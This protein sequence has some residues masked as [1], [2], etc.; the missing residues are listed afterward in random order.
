ML[1]GKGLI[2]KVYRGNGIMNILKPISIE[3]IRRFSVLILLAV[4]AWMFFYTPSDIYELKLQNYAESYK[5]K[6]RWGWIDSSTSL[7]QYIEKE[8]QGPYYRSIPKKPKVHEVK[9]ESDA[10][11]KRIVAENRRGTNDDFMQ[12]HRKKGITK[13][14]QYFFRENELPK[15]FD[16]DSLLK[17]YDY[18]SVVDQDGGKYYFS[19]YHVQ[20]NFSLSFAPASIRYPLEYYSYL[21]IALALLVYIIIPKSTVPEGAAYSIKLNAVYLPDLLSFSLWGA[22]WV[23]FFLPDDSAPTVV[24]YVFLLFFVIFALALI[25]PTIKYA[26]S[27]YLFA[28]NSFRWSGKDG[29]ESVSLDDIISIKPYTRQLPKWV[30]P[31]IILFGRGQPGATGIGMLSATAAPEVG[32]EIATNTGKKIRVMA[33]YL[34]SDETFTARFQELEKKVEGKS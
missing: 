33:N 23:F 17:D 2:I 7:E 8:M 24:R 14:N 34:E 26:S 4:F 5:D 25:F 29:I 27:W 20:R 18:L 13:S 32:M 15:E 28:E 11:L 12:K 16:S 1:N 10:F 22:G 3:Y 31:L 30:A 6:L 21:L 9:G 19:L